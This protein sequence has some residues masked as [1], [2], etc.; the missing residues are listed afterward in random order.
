MASHN[1]MSMWQADPLSKLKRLSSSR[2]RN[3]SGASS[4][5]EAGPETAQPDHFA[6]ALEKLR[7]EQDAGKSSSRQRAKQQG[8]GPADS[9]KAAG[10]A[11]PSCT[12]LVGLENHRPWKQ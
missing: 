10:D 5:L 12:V 6:A 2:L 9:A 7:R 1:A 11:R 4:R 3:A 8:A